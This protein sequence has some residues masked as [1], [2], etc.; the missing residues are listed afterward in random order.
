M[1]DTDCHIHTSFSGD[2]NSDISDIIATARTK[3]M[4]VIC[5]TDHMEV[6]QYEINE[7]TNEKVNHFIFDVDE[8]LSCIAQYGNGQLMCLGG[9]EL[10]FG[11]KQQF[12]AELIR[13][14]KKFDFVLGAS[15]FVNGLAISSEAYWNFYKGDGVRQYFISVL[16]NLERFDFIDAYAHLDAIARYG[17]RSDVYTEQRVLI[18]KILNVI[19][20]REVA[21]EINTSGYKYGLS[22]THPSFDILRTYYDLGG[23][24]ITIGSDAHHPIDIA[25]RYKELEKALFQ[26]GFTE[27]VVFKN[28]KPIWKK[29][30]YD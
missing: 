3:Q 11:H 24:M 30:S 9:I 27:Y 6:G 15:H 7:E 4:K 16:D 5:F 21:L 8:Y 28:R 19:I 20:Q 10:G 25:G 23:R 13:N 26:I 12:S 2:C 29:I 18:Q 1:I 14:L 17:N 22:N